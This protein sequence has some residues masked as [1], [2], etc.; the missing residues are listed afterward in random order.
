M[1]VFFFSL[2]R[3]LSSQ[4]EI[5]VFL[6]PNVLAF[7]CEHLDFLSCWG[8][9]RV[10]KALEV[11]R[12]HLAFSRR[13]F[14]LGVLQLSLWLPCSPASVYAAAPAPSAAGA[15]LTCTSRQTLGTWP[16][17]GPEAGLDR[18]EEDSGQGGQAGRGARACC[19][20][21]PSMGGLLSTRHYPG[22]SSCNPSGSAWAPQ[23]AGRV[24]HSMTLD[25]INAKQGRSGMWWQVT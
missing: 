10:E 8:N 21:H 11:I 23:V 9:T 22:D 15:S 24:V 20:L 5:F 17:E 1:W 19:H 3:V 4:A 13:S 25:Q 2:Y 12:N 16:Q 6:L 18:A 14:L 7:T